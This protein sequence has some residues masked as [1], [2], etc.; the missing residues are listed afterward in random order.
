MKLTHTSVKDGIWTAILSDVRGEGEPALDVR[1]ND[2]R[3]SEVTLRALGDVSGNWE[4]QVSLPAGAMSESGGLIS[5]ADPA[6]S[7]VIGMLQVTTGAPADED[8]R[9]EVTRLRQEMELVKD[10]LRRQGRS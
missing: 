2:T 9:A 10:V 5:V 8:L 7:S 1:L 4:V 6:T 3:L